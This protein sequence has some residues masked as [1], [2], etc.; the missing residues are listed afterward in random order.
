MIQ[1]RLLCVQGKDVLT[2]LALSFVCMLQESVD[3]FLFVL[4]TRFLR[5]TCQQMDGTC[6]FSH[7]I[8]KEKV[9]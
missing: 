2:K 8:D 7:K 9:S 1:Q 4:H 3:L 5:G 6:P